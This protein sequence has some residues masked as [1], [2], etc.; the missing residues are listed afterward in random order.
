MYDAL[1]HQLPGRRPA[2][3][4]QALVLLGGTVALLFL[5]VFP[6]VEPR[7]PWN[8]VVVTPPSPP[9]VSVSPSAG[10]SP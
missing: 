2:K 10:S 6:Y 4:L 8:R 3:A 9:V 5:V 7:L 1:W